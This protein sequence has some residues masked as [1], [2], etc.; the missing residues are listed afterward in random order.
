MADI[1]RKKLL[2]VESI[3]ALNKLRYGATQAAEWISDTC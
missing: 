2:P 1:P 3:S